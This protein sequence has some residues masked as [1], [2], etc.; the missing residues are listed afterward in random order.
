MIDMCIIHYILGGEKAA[1]TIPTRRQHSQKISC[2]C[3]LMRIPYPDFRANDRG[4]V[5]ACCLQIS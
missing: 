3:Y 5:T 2:L 1:S 4:L